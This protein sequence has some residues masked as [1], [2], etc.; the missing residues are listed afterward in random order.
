MQPSH[1]ERI[2]WL[3]QLER[4]VVDNQS[5]IAEAVEADF[6]DHPAALTRITELLGPVSRARFAKKHLRKWMRPQSRPVDRLLFGLAQNELRPQPIGVVGNMSPWNFP[7]DI[8]F[9]PLAD[10]LAAGCRTIIKPSEHV[11]HSAALIAELVEAYFDPDV[12]SVVTGGLALAQAFAARPWDHLL[13]TGGPE[14]AKHVMRAAAEN[15]TPLTL[16]LGGKNPTILTADRVD[17]T[18]V[19]SIVATKMV[20]A[21]QMCI[22]TDYVFVPRSKVDAFV[23]LAQTAM[24]TLYPKVID[25]SDSASIINDRHYA[26]LSGCVDE[27]RDRGTS[28]VALDPE[29]EA[30]DPE[31]RKMPLYLV[32]DPADD[33][34]VMEHEIFGPILPVKPYD[35]LDEV[36]DYVNAR[37]RP[38]CVYVFSG[39][40]RVVNRVLNETISGGAAVNAVALHAMQ[41]ALPFGGSGRSG[42]GHHHGYEGFVTFSKLKPVFRQYPVNGSSLLYPPYGSMVKRLLDFLL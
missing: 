18:S 32:L 22:T 20:K 25:N 12:V 34:E 8:S 6:G 36:L 38:L 39:D 16:E 13:F 21:G 9:G 24:K 40:R 17:A 3:G 33:L 11:P 27:A 15:L 2:A 14:I 41:P 37:P 30:A 28:V 35:T 10:T 31:R 7:F 4:M 19:T 42:M 29:N 5:R 23:E 1:A 26:R